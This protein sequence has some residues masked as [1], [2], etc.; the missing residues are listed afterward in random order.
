MALLQ[1]VAHSC[2]I[3]REMV[4]PM[5][6]D[7]YVVL[8]VVRADVRSPIFRHLRDCFWPEE[9]KRAVLPVVV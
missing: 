2:Q 6:P 3:R 5:P 7:L 1:R 9:E 8:S 4:I